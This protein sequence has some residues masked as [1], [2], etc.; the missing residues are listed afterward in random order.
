MHTQFSAADGMNICRIDGRQAIENI[1]HTS[2]NLVFAIPIG[3]S[4]SESLL[5]GLH[6]LIILVI[7]NSVASM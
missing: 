2:T 1:I 3:Q 5:E 6:L 4:L 7:D